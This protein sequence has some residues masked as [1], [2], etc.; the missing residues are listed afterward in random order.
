MP[1]GWV[2]SEPGAALQGGVVPAVER[3]AVGGNGLCLERFVRPAH[4]H[5]GGDSTQNVFLTGKLQHLS[6]GLILHQ[7]GTALGGC[8]DAA[9]EDTA[10]DA[11]SAP[12]STAR[13][14]R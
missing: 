1:P 7:K 11:G 3:I 6:G 12:L 5:L 13:V 4:R 9:G 10:E 14:I 8:A 2:G